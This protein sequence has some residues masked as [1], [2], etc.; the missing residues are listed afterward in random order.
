[1]S[2]EHTLTWLI[3]VVGLKQVPEQLQS[4][5]KVRMT[6]IIRQRKTNFRMKIQ[7]QG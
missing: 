2:Q 4:N 3:Q 7:R 5:H 6:A 1:M